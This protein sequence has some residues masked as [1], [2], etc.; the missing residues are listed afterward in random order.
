M[1]VPERV[2]KGC[3]DLG[4]GSYLGA[5]LAQS[6]RTARGTSKGYWTKMSM[7]SRNIVAA[8][9]TGV[10]SSMAAMMVP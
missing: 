7:M 6:Q 9:G 10:G 5:I 8:E 1:L 4:I 2:L 3:S